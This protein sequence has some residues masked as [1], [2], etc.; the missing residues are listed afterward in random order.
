MAEIRARKGEHWEKCLTAVRR[1]AIEFTLDITFAHVARLILFVPSE[2]AIH[3]A[4][5]LQFGGDASRVL[6]VEF[7]IEAS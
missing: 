3:P 2:A 1:I 5:A 6:A 4:V 7:V